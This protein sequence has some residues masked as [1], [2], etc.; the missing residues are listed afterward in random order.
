MDPATAADYDR[1][2]A[3]R[4]FLLFAFA[5]LVICVAFYGIIHF[6]ETIRRLA[7]PNYS[8]VARESHNGARSGSASPFCF[9]LE[10]DDDRALKPVFCDFQH[11]DSATHSSLG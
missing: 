9:R 4:A 11:S 7:A 3:L 2:T 5:V 8:S 1:E 10:F 6:L